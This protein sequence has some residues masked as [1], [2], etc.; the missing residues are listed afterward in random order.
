M[1]AGKAFSSYFVTGPK[2]RGDG[3]RTQQEEYLT[4]F[5]NTVTDGSAF[6]RSRWDWSNDITTGKWSTE[7]QVYTSNRTN[8]NVSRRRLLVRGSGPAV[9]FYFRSDADKPFEIIGWTAWESTDAVP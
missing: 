1:P 9:Q 2:I 5:A 6:V 3:N 4:V 8:R 7:Q